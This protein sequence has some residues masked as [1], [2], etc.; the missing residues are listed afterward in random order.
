L[1]IVDRGPYFSKS[2]G[3]IDT[4]SEMLHKRQV[5]RVIA[6]GASSVVAA[7]NKTAAV[8]KNLIVG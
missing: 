2:R 6:V 4:A 7:A 5:E 8:G 1:L 3:T